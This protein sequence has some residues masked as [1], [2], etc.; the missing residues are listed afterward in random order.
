MST[1]LPWCAGP[2]HWAGT[3]NVKRL[4]HFVET[5][6]ILADRARSLSRE[7]D[8]ED[9]LVLAHGPGDDRENEPWIASID[10][11]AEEIRRAVPFHVV[12]VHTLREDWPDRRRLAEQRIR[13]SVERAS[14][15]GRRAIVI[16][17]RV[18]GFGP[19]AEVLDGLEY[20]ADGRGLL[21]DSRVS[22]W[23]AGQAAELREG[24]F[25]TPQS[26]NSSDRRLELGDLWD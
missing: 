17:L 23:I 1:R 20:V 11:R 7:P 19:Y 25:R 8:K 26:R 14:N 3:V 24:P 16:P 4:E 2:S 5:G 9:V 10:A 13:V 22:E 18:H 12:E 6:R 21:P 15:S